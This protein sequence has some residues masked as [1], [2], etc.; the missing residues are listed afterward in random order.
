MNKQLTITLIS[1]ILAS[2]A[3]VSA[4]L[5]EP[6]RTVVAGE[7][8]GSVENAPSVI[9]VIFTDPTISEDDGIRVAT[10]VDKQPAFKAE[11]KVLFAQN[12]TLQ[13][14]SKFYNIFVS[15]GDSIYMKF[16]I[17]NGYQNPVITFSGD[18][19]DFNQ[20]FT[21]FIG[22]LYSNVY[23]KM[24]RIDVKLP[25]DQIKQQFKD[26]VQASSDSIDA[27]ALRMKVDP[28]VKQW[29]KR[30]VIYYFANQF[31]SYSPENLQD[32]LNL[33]RDPIFDI[34]NSE[35]F[36]SMFFA[37]YLYDYMGS[38]SPCDPDF[39]KAQESKDLIVMTKAFVECLLKEPES[40]S[41]DFMFYS[42]IINSKM[43][44]TTA[45][46]S[47]DSCFSDPVFAKM[48]KARIEKS[49]K[50]EIFE[51][52]DLKGISYLAP[53]SI[54]QNVGSVDLIDLLRKKH[55][56]KV[57]YIDVYATWCG[58]CRAEMPSSA[59]L[60]KLYADKDVVFV[61]LC[62]ASESSAW[63]PMIRKYHIAGENYFLDDNATPLF[64]STYKLPG[65]PSYMVID[66]KGNVSTRDVPRP[67]SI[68]TVSLLFDKL[69]KN[70]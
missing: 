3:V 26:M 30:D 7:I 11:R 8:V 9:T 48:I 54:I 40:L 15:P 63:I 45:P 61:Y 58:P 62:L 52:V 53:D 25:V 33:L 66:P 49:K 20:Q 69:L 36:T 18:G 22:Y 35:N 19:A 5:Q 17:S 38:V 41:R 24:G 50:P 28:K 29:A 55:A 34:S 47:I 60:H 4:Q 67:S 16:D 39:I 6:R 57:V 56:G 42:F 13:Y 44:L 27:C 51:S 64:M 65:Y 21:P 68:G 2:T 1:M 70:E 43:D 14:G 10:A 31:V 46:F 32:K 37:Y 23:N 59:E 12:M